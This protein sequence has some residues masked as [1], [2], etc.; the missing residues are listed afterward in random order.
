MKPQQPS[1][2]AETVA[3][4][5]QSEAIAAAGFDD[6]RPPRQLNVDIPA[7]QYDHL[8]VICKKKGTTKRQVVQQL[9][10]AYTLTAETDRTFHL[11]GCECPLSKLIAGI[12]E[13]IRRR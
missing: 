13:E 11:D 12:A 1:T 7:G 8:T 9:I 3:A 6:S 5:L 2:T 4:G 10:D